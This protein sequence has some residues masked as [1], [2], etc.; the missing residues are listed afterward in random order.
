VVDDL[1][2]GCTRWQK[3]HVHPRAIECLESAHRF[4][5][6]TETLPAHQQ[7]ALGMSTQLLD[8]SQAIVAGEMVRSDGKIQA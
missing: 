7:W 3:L 8:K 5:V 2:V 4:A 1:G 6:P